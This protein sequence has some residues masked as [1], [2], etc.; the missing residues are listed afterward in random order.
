MTGQGLVFLA[1]LDLT[2]GSQPSSLG[3]PDNA[4]RNLGIDRT[5]TNSAVKTKNFSRLFYSKSLKKY[6]NNK[7]Y[8]FLILLF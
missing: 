8:Y 6:K 2:N 1:G 7:L 3:G 4:S 5:T